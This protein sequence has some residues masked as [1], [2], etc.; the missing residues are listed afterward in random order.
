M[1]ESQTPSKQPAGAHS[2]AWSQGLQTRTRPTSG[3]ASTPTSRSWR[4]CSTIS[5]GPA[6]TGRTS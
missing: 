6:R 2:P 4:G 1:V 3:A 5:T